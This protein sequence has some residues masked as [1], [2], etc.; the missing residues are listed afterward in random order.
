M[1]FISY[2]DVKYLSPTSLLLK[3]K[4]WFLRRFLKNQDND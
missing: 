4:I 2:T 1:I 3:P